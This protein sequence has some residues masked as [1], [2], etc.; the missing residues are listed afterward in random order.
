MAAIERD[1]AIEEEV[2]RIREQERTI[3]E[4]GWA[5]GPIPRFR[6][7]G[8]MSGFDRQRLGERMSTFLPPASP[9]MTQRNSNGREVGHCCV[10][11]CTLTMELI[12][13]CHICRR[14][15]HMICAE[16]FSNLSEDE[17][18]CSACYSLKK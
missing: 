3:A 6:N 11:G 2:V 14:F 18:Y 8:D 12:H 15:I 7:Y 13:R 10:T 5:T 1:V 4:E 17:R 16:P 9:V